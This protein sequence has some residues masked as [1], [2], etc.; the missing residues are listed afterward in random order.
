VRHQIQIFPN[1]VAADTSR[2]YPMM[3]PSVG[4]WGATRVGDLPGEKSEVGG[5]GPDG[6]R[7]GRVGGGGGRLSARVAGGF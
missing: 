5:R 1:V 2:E 3:V 6:E 7:A 4:Q